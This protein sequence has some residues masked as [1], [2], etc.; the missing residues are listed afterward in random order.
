MSFYLFVRYFFSQRAGSLIKFV[1]R[2]S[3]AGIAISVAALILIVSVMEGFGKAVKSRTLDNQAHLTLSFTENPFLKPI[4]TPTKE[5]FINDK[6]KELHFLNPEQKKVLKSSQVFEKQELILNK[7]ELFQ[8]VSAKG[9]S[10][11]QWNKIKNQSLKQAWMNMSPHSQPTSKERADSQNNSLK[12]DS[13]LLKDLPLLKNS[14]PSRDLLISYDLAFK[15]E[16]KVGDQVQILP[17]GGLLLPAQILPPI[18]VFTIAGILQED[19]THSLYY[20]QGAMD[21]GEFSKIYYQAELQLK[22]PNKILEQEKLF[23]NYEVKNWMEKNSYLFFALKLEKFIMIL[24]FSIALIISCLGVSSSLLL[25]INQ[26]T[27]DIAILQA[28]GS[29]SKSLTQTFKNIGLYLSSL[30]L[31]LGTGI[32][33]LIVLFLK[34][35]QFNLLP[36]MYQDRTIPAVFVPMSYVFILS[37]TFLLCWFFCYLSS[38]YFSQISI[39]SLLKDKGY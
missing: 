8:G 27:E 19:A 32:G 10:K 14:E 36:E 38:R 26:K 29:S 33:L 30:G 1:S 2:L 11:K 22:E 37:G 4:K 34:Y 23:K 9:Y 6:N 28:L 31:L 18:K 15:T 3:L 13:L 35:N 21:F 17:L 7:D 5:L 20:E 24:F 16:L 12:T 39:V 25:L